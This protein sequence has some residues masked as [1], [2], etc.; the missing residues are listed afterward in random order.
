M[1]AFNFSFIEVFKFKKNLDTYKLMN[2]AWIEKS[3]VRYRVSEKRNKS[4]K[5]I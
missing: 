2:S 5:Y 4:V 3:G 1:H